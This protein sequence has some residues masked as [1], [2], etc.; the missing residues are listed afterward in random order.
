MDSE[1]PAP[2]QAQATAFAVVDQAVDALGNVED[3]S[4][5]KSNEEPALD[6]ASIIYTNGIKHHFSRVI[7]D[8]GQKVKNGA[9]KVHRAVFTLYTGI[10]WIVTA[11][12]MMNSVNDLLGYLN[13]IWRMS[14]SAHEDP[15]DPKGFI[16][17]ERLYTAEFA[18]EF[19]AEH[20]DYGSKFKM[21]DA[22]PTDVDCFVLDPRSFAYLVNKQRLHGRVAHDVVRRILNLLQLKITT[23]TVIDVN[24]T[25]FRVGDQIPRYY[26]VVVEL[27]LSSIEEERYEAVFDAWKD[28]IS[29]PRGSGKTQE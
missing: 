27:G 25:P 13:L 4:R 12:P 15:R 21:P 20:Q 18:Q 2:M 3:A 7:L 28:W 14:W 10:K 23:S 24:D 17:G 9:T 16:T 22:K 29:R 26:T 1:P 8:E 5:S 11:T 6:D 19:R